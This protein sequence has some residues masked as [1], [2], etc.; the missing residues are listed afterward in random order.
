MDRPRTLF[1]SHGSPM[2]AV[3]ASPASRF[4][5][6]LGRA[7]PKPAAIVAVSAHWRAA[8]P[9]VGAAARPATIHD[10]LG[11]PPALYAIDYPAPG[12][13]ALAARLAESLGGEADPHRGLDHGVW[14]VARL[15]WPEADIPIVPLALPRQGAGHDYLALGR[16]LGAAVEPGTLILATGAATHNLSAY[17]GQPRDVPAQDWVIAFTDWLGC[18]VQAGDAD[19]L[20][21]YRG[22]APFAHDNHPTDEHLTPLLVAAGAAGRPGRVLHRSVEHGVIAMDCYGW[23]D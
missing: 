3:E 7:M 13:R 21:D 20:A 8:R 11:F 16:A 2:I 5:A 17:V 9:L 1:V 12:D 18:Q 10:F 6:E 23:L 19:A 14:T 15:M 22:Q 4:L